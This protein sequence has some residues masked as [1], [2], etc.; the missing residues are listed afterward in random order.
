MSIVQTTALGL[1]LMSLLLLM[2]VRT[3]LIDQWRASLPDDTP[4][5]FMVNIQPDQADALRED[6]AALGVD[7]LQVRPMAN[8]NLVELTGEDPPE[9][10]FTGQVNLSWIDELPP[11]NVIERGRFWSPGATGEISLA[12]RWAE[13]V[14]VG[15]G[16]RLTFDAGGRTFSGE[17]TSLREVDWGSFNVN[18]FILVTPEAAGDLP[19]QYV[20][21][22]RAPPDRLEALDRIA[23]DRP[24][25]TLLDVGALVDRVFQII[26]Q[27]SRA[28]QVVFAFTLVAGLVV[29]LAALE[30]TRDQR[31][32]EAALLRTLGA[33]RRMVRGG[34]LV[35]Y[36]VMAVI[37]AGLA[38]AGAAMVGGLLAGELFG[39]DYRPGAGLFVLG[40]T[41]SVVLIVGA[42]WLGNRD[43]LKTPPVR[44]LRAR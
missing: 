23:R 33:P 4:D 16:D 17:V 3:E 21:S 34:L 39:F 42:G 43:V 1:G 19:H 24:N 36:G 2:V 30:A 32:S 12:N 6:L 38:V 14:G 5:H 18:F 8:A 29:L 40:F 11:A 9:N 27:V 26:D 25:V 10:A 31:R 15:L 44:I 37:A 22:F 20:A 7:G 13:R 28:A 35:E 41:V